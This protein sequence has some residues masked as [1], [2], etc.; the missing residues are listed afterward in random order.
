MNRAAT[1]DWLKT[2]LHWTALRAVRVALLAAAGLGALTSPSTAQ[3]VTASER[4]ATG[5][6]VGGELGALYY[7]DAC[8]ASA[9]SCD[10][11][12]WTAAV[13]GG[14]QINAH[15]AL[16]LSYR[17]LG[18]ARAVYPR[19]TST[20][21]VSGNVQGYELAAL[22]SIPISRAWQAYLR[23]GAFYWDAETRSSEFRSSEN[24]WSP[25]VGAGVAWQFRPAWK[26]RIEYLYLANLGGA[27]TGESSGA[28]L[29][30]GVCYVFGGSRPP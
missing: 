10:R 14:Y 18:E 19:L 29:S 6:Y 17:D 5:F 20:L 12:T 25:S 26:T 1:T 21:E 22:A 3:D 24:G 16:E 30:V 28:I 11:G 8:E 2:R 27:K 13:F 23:G 9:V 15:L 7:T 4:Y